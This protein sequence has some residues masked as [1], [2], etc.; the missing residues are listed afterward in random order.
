MRLSG[1]YLMTPHYSGRSK[2]ADKLSIDDYHKWVKQQALEVAESFELIDGQIRPLPNSPEQTRMLRLWQWQLQS[3]LN[4]EN[5]RAKNMQDRKNGTIRT[6]WNTQFEMQIRPSFQLDDFNELKPAI[7]VQKVCAS[8]AQKLEVES[9]PDWIVDVLEMSENSCNKSPS[10]SLSPAQ[11]NKTNASLRQHRAQLY[12]RAA[13]SDYWSL[14]L[15]STELQ[16]YQQ[17]SETGYQ[18]HRVLQVGDWASPSTVPLTVKLQEPVPLYFMTRTLRGQ[19]TYESRA[20][21]ISLSV[22]QLD[23]IS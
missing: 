2:T 4:V 1:I 23:P 16:L 17:P 6:D 8:T 19:Q 22:A 15:E 18:Q 10:K 14:S 11:S 13:V 3:L 12:A 21:P 9:A 7:L 20:L 5:I